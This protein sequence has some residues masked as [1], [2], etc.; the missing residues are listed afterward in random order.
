MFKNKAFLAA[1][2]VAAVAI[3]VVGASLSV[4]KNDS[5][6]RYGGLPAATSTKVKADDA[7][8]TDNES[9]APVEQAPEAVEVENVAVENEDTAEVAAPEQTATA[10]DVAVQPAA[11]GESKIHI[12]TAQ[13]MKYEPVVVMIQPGDMVAWENMPTHDTQSIEGLI[14]EGAESWHSKMGENYQRTFTVE[15][16]YVYK[17]TPHV[18]AGMGGAIIVGNPVNLEAIKAADVKGAERRL[19]RAALAEVEKM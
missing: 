9:A 19:V 14:P 15:G 2:V 12:V 4:F 17:C 13:G 7:T 5:D 1:V 18:G 16:I 10:A 3:F 6:K 11:V 8:N